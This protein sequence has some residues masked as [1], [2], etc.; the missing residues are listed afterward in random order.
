MKPAHDLV[1]TCDS[2]PLDEHTWPEDGRQIPAVT[3]GGSLRLSGHAEMVYHAGRKD[4]FGGDRVCDR[5]GVVQQLWSSRNGV[6]KGAC[7]RV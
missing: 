5:I 4:P 3:S 2:F 1:D 7:V 6:V